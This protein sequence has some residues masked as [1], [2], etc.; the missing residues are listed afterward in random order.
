MGKLDN[1]VAIITGGNSG[2][3]LETAKLFTSEG[4]KVII[5]GR[6]KEAV[7]DAVK[8]IGKNSIG[9]VGDVADINAHDEL[10]NLV[11]ENFNKVDIYFA[12]A[13][14][15]PLADFQNTTL[16]MFDEQ[17]SV[18]VRGLYFGI[19][20]MLPIFS[21][22]GSIILTG[23]IASY[24]IFEAHNVYAAT[25]S[26]IRSFARSWTKDL[27]KQ[28]IRVNI[29]SPGPTKTPILGKM[30]L[31]EN[32]IKLIEEQLANEIPLGRMADSID[33]AKA[34]LFLASEDSSFIS[35]IELSV[36]GGMAQI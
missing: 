21:N 25:K 31:N 30:G 33:I 23:S 20:K 18:N 9:F 12:N 26:A 8:I 3:G 27:I 17:F 16:E 14:I 5:T 19:Q 2:I 29:L 22:G 34:A 32:D 15:N 35:G 10:V 7:H 1:K 28:K 36:D 24:K 4:A 13:A 11:K 6:R